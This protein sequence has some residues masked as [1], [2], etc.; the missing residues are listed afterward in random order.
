MY[1]KNLF[2]F[3]KINFLIKKITFLENT[4]RYSL[5]NDVYDIHL[6]ISDYGDNIIA[7]STRSKLIFSLI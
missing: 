3:F 1:S 2:L 5:E 7:T 4:N 6:N